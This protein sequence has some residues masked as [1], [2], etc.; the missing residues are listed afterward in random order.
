VTVV[1]TAAES[2]EPA[3]SIEAVVTDAVFENGL[4]PPHKGGTLKVAVIVRVAPGESVPS[5]HGKATVQSPAFDTNTRPLGVGS[6]TLTD[7][8]LPGPLLLTV[9]V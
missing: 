3:G 8:A 1:D 2:L 7:V 6:E 9:I 4:V 5:A